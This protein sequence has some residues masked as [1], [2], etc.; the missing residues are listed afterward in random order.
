MV[1]KNRNSNYGSIKNPKSFEPYSFAKDRKYPYYRIYVK[2]FVIY[3][4]VVDDK[5]DDF[6]IMEVR[7]ILYN[8]RDK[9][10]LI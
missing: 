10:K 7:H 6:K 3:Y 2:S 9:R 4:V 8:K 5:A 1:E